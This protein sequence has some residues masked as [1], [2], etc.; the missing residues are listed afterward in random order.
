MDKRVKTQGKMTEGLENFFTKNIPPMTKISRNYSLQAPNL[1]N[2]LFTQLEQAE[3]AVFGEF[4]IRG[5]TN[6]ISNIDFMAVSFGL[7]QILYIQSYQNNNQDF[8]SGVNRKVDKSLTEELGRPAF[9]GDIWVSLND[10]IRYGYG[11]EPTTE[12]KKRAEATLKALEN[13]R[14]I[15]SYPGLAERRAKLCSVIDEVR[16]YKD[17]S[18]YY[19][20][21]LHPLFCGDIKNQFGLCPSH[22]MKKL[23]TSLKN[24]GLR[25][26]E[27]HYLILNWL[28]LQDKRTPKL[29]N[30]ETFVKKAGIEEE[31]SKYRSRAEK[32]IISI[33]ESMVDIGLLTRFE[34][35]YITLSKKERVSSIIVIFNPNFTR[36]NK[37][38]ENNS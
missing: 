15:I 12:L 4:T 13:N 2:D 11:D 10:I 27:G 17:G 1:N 6:N 24:K 18:I 31:Y 7:A 35:N 22:V 23:S 36:Q 34:L 37:M 28:I 19:N 21:H 25:K 9:Y 29:F 38:I 5:E 16:L 32:K 3:Q 26:T 8:N 30:I 20:L 14:L 33:C